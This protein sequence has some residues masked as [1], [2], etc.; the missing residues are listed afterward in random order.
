MSLFTR[1]LYPLELQYPGY[2]PFPRMGLQMG[3]ALQ[4]NILIVNCGDFDKILDIS[5]H[6]FVLV[7]EGS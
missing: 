6:I 3:S 5:T 7:K 4:V 2:S 1:A